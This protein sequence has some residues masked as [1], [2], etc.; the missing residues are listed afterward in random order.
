MY[1]QRVFT[2]HIKNLLWIAPF[3]S[4]FIGYRLLTIWFDESSFNMP[5]LTGKSAAQALDILSMYRL[6]PS[7]VA[8]K[9]TLGIQAGTILEQT[10][11]EGTLI[12]KNQSVYLVVSR[13]P[14]QAMIPYLVGKTAHEIELIVETT[15]F[16]LDV[17]AIPN[18]Y[19]PIGNCFAYQLINTNT[20]SEKKVIAYISAGNKDPKIWPNFKGEPYE[21]VIDF[22]TSY[23]IAPRIIAIDNT[24]INENSIVLDQRPAAGSIIENQEL[25]GIYVQ[26][27]VGSP[28]GNA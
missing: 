23:Q 9:E 22:L 8:Y 14:K 3:C 20:T 24:V 5:V 4:F 10:P 21:K 18:S 28:K 25:P 13:E 7:I 11:I 6:I 17:Y 2:V 12:K 27:L 15:P 26:L 19:H 1:P 16:K